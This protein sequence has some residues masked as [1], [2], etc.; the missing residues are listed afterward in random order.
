MKKITGLYIFLLL[1]FHFS[2]TAQTDTISQRII[3]VGDAGELT[4][5]RHPVVDAI[6][7]FIKLDKKT[8]VIFLG[9]NLYDSGLPD[10]Q[11]ALYQQSKAVLDSQLSVVEGTQARVIMIPGNH[12]WNNGAR[13]GYETIIREQVYVDILNKPNVS[14]YP[15]DGCPGPVEVDLG[16]DVTVIIFDSQWWIHTY[17]K[18]GI[19][20]DCNCKT[21]EELL[22]QIEDMVTRNSKKLVLLAS[23]HPFKSNSVHG[24]NFQLKQHIFPFT[25]INP[26]L[27]IPLPIIGSIY[28]IARSVFGT[29][30]DLSHPNYQNMINQVTDAVKSHPHVV[31]VAGHDHGLQLIRDSSYNYIVSGGG[32]KTNRVSKGKNSLYAASERGFAVM[33]VSTNKNVTVSFYTVTDSVRNSFG[34]TLLNFSSVPE[35]T[36]DS[37]KRDV[38]I[39]NIKYKDTVNI[40]AS[41]KYKPVSGFKKMVLGQNYRSEWT[42]PVNMKVFNINKER[43]GFTATGMGGSKQTLSLHLKEKKT[44]KEWVLRAVDKLPLGALPPEYR[45]TIAPD[46][47]RE[48][49]SASHPYAPLAIPDLA[50]AL[51]IAVPHAE[52][53][54]VPDDPALG[55]Y[56]PL[57]KNSVCIL[58]EK[59]PSL[60]GSNTKSTAKIFNDMIEEND[61]RADQFAVLRAR[62]LDIII[63]DFDRNLDQ[64]KWATRRERL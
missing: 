57:F 32:S 17:D 47:I 14:F 60:D 28:P 43:G 26:K 49:N 1:G 56:Q 50:K 52:L 5:G 62:L 7:Q 59:E 22:T 24:G 20:S 12:D 45:G 31:F 61:H 39:T 40:S 30:Q 37:A 35:L 58:E 2:L 64:W 25:D 4:N 8:T 21:N 36:G 42:T 63:G 3:L 10:D 15:K 55:Y 41:D 29:P 9:D 11:S 13:D 53:F 19:E 33:E 16:N 54:F 27:W 23:H 38:N 6:K 18:P 44:G 51:N 48:F 46:L 34:T